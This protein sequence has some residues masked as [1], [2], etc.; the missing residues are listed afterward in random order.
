MKSTVEANKNIDLRYGDGAYSKP[1][2]VYLALFTAAPGVGGGGT[3]VTGGSY[4]RLAVT[5]NLANFPD[6]AAGIKSNGVAFTFIQATAA[7]G[8]VIAVGIF[9]ASTAGNLLDFANLTTPK[10]VGNGDVLSFPI[11]SMVFTET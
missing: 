5:N 8:T 3:E 2:T 1:A 9:D 6:A 10:T 7:W 4:V 11:G